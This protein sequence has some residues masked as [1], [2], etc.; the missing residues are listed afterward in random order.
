MNMKK[1]YFTPTLEVIEMDAENLI[2]N[3][4]GFGTGPGEEDTPLSNKRQPLGGTWSSDN[5]KQVE[6]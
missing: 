6:E 4:P 3:S 1:V 5:W 2:A